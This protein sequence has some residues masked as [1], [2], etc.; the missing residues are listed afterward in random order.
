M[1][2]ESQS[3][4]VSRF[5]GLLAEGEE[6]L[7][8][9]ELKVAASRFIGALALWRGPALADFTFE[10]FAQAEI[11]RLEELKLLAEERRIDAEPWF[12]AGFR[13]LVRYSGSSG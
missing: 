5:E 11:A 6:A 12:H 1:Q 13:G 9:A 8:M 4:D 3:V 7:A 2:V 10:P